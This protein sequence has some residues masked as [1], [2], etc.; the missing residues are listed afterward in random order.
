MNQYFREQRQNTGVRSELQTTMDLLGNITVGLAHNAAEGFEMLQNAYDPYIPGPKLT[1]VIRLAR[2]YTG[3]A[4]DTAREQLQAIIPMQDVKANVEVLNR[5]V[6]NILAQFQNASAD[7]VGNSSLQAWATNIAREMR[8]TQQVA[9]RQFQRIKA[10]GLPLVNATLSM[11]NQQVNTTAGDLRAVFAD[12][13][14]AYPNLN[15]RVFFNNLNNTMRE[16][17]MRASDTVNT[18]RAAAT[19]QEVCKV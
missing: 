14:D 17:V 4:I 7:V 1:D 18:F 15:P 2:N 9:Q 11:I 19:N 8:G 13:E 16:L 5:T 12:A 10:T 6:D 3:N